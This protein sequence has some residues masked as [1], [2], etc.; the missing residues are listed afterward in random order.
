MSKKGANIMLQPPYI[1]TETWGEL[2]ENKDF[3][4]FFIAGKLVNL[5]YK[6][7]LKYIL[8]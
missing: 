3:V 8:T 5:L 6:G 7:R 4:K 2:L 1:F